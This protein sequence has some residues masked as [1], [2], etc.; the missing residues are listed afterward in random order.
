[1]E[2]LAILLIVA[3]IVL[4]AMGPKSQQG[5]GKDGGKAL[6]VLV[7]LVAMFTLVAIGLSQ[8]SM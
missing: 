7:G 3:L 8:C 5:L 1:M 6:L 4:V 2:V